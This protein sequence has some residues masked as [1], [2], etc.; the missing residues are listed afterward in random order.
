MLRIII[1]VIFLYFLTLAQVSWPLPN[2]VFP[3]V[4]LIS[5]LDHSRRKA[6]LIIAIFSGFFL[7]IFSGRF[8][9]F[10]IV[11]LVAIVVAVKYFLKKYFR[12]ELNAKIFGKS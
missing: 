5:V 12:F 2:L 10:W 11:V 3:L 9:G 6:S 8:F 7:D 1:L 4:V